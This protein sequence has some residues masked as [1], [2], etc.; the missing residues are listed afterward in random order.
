VKYKS[1]IV[2]QNVR[3]SLQFYSTKRMNVQ[4]VL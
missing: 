3:S 1:L 4:K 2:K